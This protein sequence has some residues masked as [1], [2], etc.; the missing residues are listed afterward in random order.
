MYEFSLLDL[1]PYIIMTVLLTVIM[2]SEGAPKKKASACFMLMFVF[3]AIRY[4]IGYD[5]YGYVQTVLHQVEDYKLARHEPF[6]RVLVEIGYQTHYQI[7]FV[8]CAFLT[9]FPL[10]KA[11]VKLSINPAFS[12]LI[13]FLFPRYYLESFSIV[14]NAMSYS[15]VLYAFVFLYHKKMLWSV[16][17]MVSAA[18]FHK[19]AIIGV[20]I[21]PLYYLRADL[22]LNV[23]IYIASFVA[24][25]LM[26]G[27]IGD[28]TSLLPFLDVVEHY[29]EFARDEGGTMTYIINCLC[30]FHFFVWKKLSRLNPA[31]EK[32][33]VFFSIGGCIWNIFLPIDSTLALRLSSFFQIFIIFLVP[34]YK[35]TVSL[36][37]KRTVALC[38]Y[39]FFV[40]L[41]ASY[42]YINVSSYLKK[43]DRMSNLP[44]QTIF[45]HKDYSNYIY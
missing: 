14:R 30:V 43:P 22:K 17:M 27:F 35:Y 36:A 40:L 7:Y 5:Y 29:A 4:G 44:Y 28:L 39:G 6:S 45:Y 20:L 31:N 42:F 13:Y 16:I 10:Y 1:M 12:L 23:I 21:Y 2:R 15:F 37:Y 34:Q 19:S 41:F 18:M 25:N 9:L 8:L 32:Y 24:S 33:L 3:S 11:C 38:S 26:M